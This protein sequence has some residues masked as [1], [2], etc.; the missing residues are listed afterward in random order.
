MTVEATDFPDTAQI[1][2]LLAPNAGLAQEDS[3]TEAATCASREDY[4]NLAFQT[5]EVRA[6]TKFIHGICGEFS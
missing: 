4:A 5:S 3:M 6:A 2:D 1:L